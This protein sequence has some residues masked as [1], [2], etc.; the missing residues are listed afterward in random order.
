MSEPKVISAEEARKLLEGATPGPWRFESHP[1]AM[2]LAAGDPG[3]VGTF[4]MNHGRFTTLRPNDAALIAAAPSLAATVIALTA[5][6]D[7]ATAEL[8]ALRTP[9]PNTATWSTR[10]VGPY[11]GW[12]E[13]RR[14]SGRLV[15]RYIRRTPE[16]SLVQVMVGGKRYAMPG[17]ELARAYITERLPKGV[18]VVGG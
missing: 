11:K 16:S 6:R 17:E 3:C 10:T 18:E 14:A 2:V 7:A 12:T 5:E 15:G 9:K 4:P 13:L 8:T 1:P